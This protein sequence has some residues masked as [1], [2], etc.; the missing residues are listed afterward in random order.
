M[1]LAP[2][3]TF[4]WDGAALSIVVFAIPLAILATTLTIFL[5][6]K[7]VERAMRFSAGEIV[8]AS[9]EPDEKITAKPLKITVDANA[10]D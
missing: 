1:K 10:K 8:A 9:L 6:R 7:S 5:Y 3:C 4:A 2:E